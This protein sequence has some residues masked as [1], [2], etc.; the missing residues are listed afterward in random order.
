M[1]FSVSGFSAVKSKYLRSSISFIFSLKADSFE[2]FNIFFDLIFL[3]DCSM[4]LDIWTP[5]LYQYL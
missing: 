4:L 2:I 3:I 1:Y 5:F